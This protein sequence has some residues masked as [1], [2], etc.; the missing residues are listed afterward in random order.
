MKKSVFKENF[1][2][3]PE[4]RQRWEG[5]EASKREV[6]FK[7]FDWLFEQTGFDIYA[8]ERDQGQLFFGIYGQA[9]ALYRLG[10]ACIEKD[11]VRVRLRNRL[12]KGILTPRQMAV[13]G[14]VAASSEETPHFDYSLTA[15]NFESIIGLIQGCLGAFED[16]LAAGTERVLPFSAIA[17]DELV[18]DA[19]GRRSMVL[20]G[21]EIE[22]V[23]K[24]RVGQDGF[25]KALLK[26][27]GG[28]A[29]TGVKDERL[30]VASHI[31]P[32]SESNAPEKVDVD[33]GLLL[34]PALDYAFDA[35]LISF[36]GAGGIMIAAEVKDDLAA[37]GISASMTL[38]QPL[39][40][41]QQRYLEEHRRV[42]DSRTQG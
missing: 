15:D 26:R 22:V 1:L 6:Y 30:L 2:V 14:G 35:Y 37:I 36:D 17:A 8:L 12:Y 5:A 11:R 18:P 41:G 29:V 23:A 34:S 31:K 40:Q 13:A 19:Q 33:N 10:W 28:C 38:S 4:L 20:F 42:F 9:R 16:K 27:W 25:R 32:W 21:R 39:T 3:A 7:L 24:L